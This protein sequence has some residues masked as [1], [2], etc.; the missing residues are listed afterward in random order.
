MT[1]SLDIPQLENA[2]LRFPVRYKTVPG[3]WTGTSWRE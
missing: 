1:G 2:A 3:A